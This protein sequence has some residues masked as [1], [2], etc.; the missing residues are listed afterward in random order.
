MDIITI[1]LIAIGLSMDCFAVSIAKAG[2]LNKFD[3]GKFLQWLCY[4]ALF[5]VLCLLLVTCSDIILLR[6][7]KV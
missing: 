6:I 7:S 5:K 2:T 3:F 4:S 1:V